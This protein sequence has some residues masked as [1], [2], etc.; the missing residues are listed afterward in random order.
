MGSLKKFKQRL[1]RYSEKSI[2]NAFQSKLNL[3]NKS[4]ENKP[5]NNYQN[6]RFRCGRNTRGRGRGNFFERKLN[7]E[8]SSQRCNICKR[9]SHMEK[10]CWFKG[11]PQ[12][13]NCKKFGH[14]VKDCR[15]KNTQE[16]NFVA[17]SEGDSSLFYAC[18]SN[19]K[20]EACY[21]SSGCKSDE[22]T[23]W[24]LDSGCTNHMTANEA[25]FQKV[26]ATP[27]S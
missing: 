1:L 2:E 10:D 8:S 6:M 20:N 5:Q 17:E 15:L 21:T 4:S 18:Q 7:E 27:N 3:G 12:C 19:E 24:F 26:E 25:I 23:K 13:F 16:V 14:V 11:K 9:S 22:E